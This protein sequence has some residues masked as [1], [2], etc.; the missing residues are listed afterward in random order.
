MSQ[1]SDRRSFLSKTL[2]IKSCILLPYGPGQATSWTSPSLCPSSDAP[3]SR[4]HRE[5]SRFRFTVTFKFIIAIWEAD[6]RREF[7]AVRL[8]LSIIGG[9]TSGEK[10]V[11]SEIMSG[12]SIHVD[13]A[14][15]RSSL[16]PYAE[17]RW[18]R[19][20]SGGKLCLKRV[21]EYFS[22]FQRS[23]PTWHFLVKKSS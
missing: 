17:S 10:E 12:D 5:C 4:R 2:K 18:E 7:E 13:P 14:R 23:T 3:C 19:T 1:S 20:W 11:A 15:L 22:N 8:E 9:E 21:R 6:L 16:D